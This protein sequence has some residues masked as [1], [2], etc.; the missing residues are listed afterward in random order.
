MNIIGYYGNFVR[1]DT[2]NIIL[3]FADRGTLDEYLKNTHE[4][5]NISEI[6]FFWERFLAIMKGLAHLHGT[7]ESDSNEPGILLGYIIS[8]AF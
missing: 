2:Y 3:E 1:D 8:A 6:M 5:T 7:A 4:P